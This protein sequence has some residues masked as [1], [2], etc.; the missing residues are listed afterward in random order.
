MKEILFSA[1]SSLTG[2]ALRLTLGII[3][4]PHGAQ[5]LFGLF[6]GYGYKET[7]KYFTDN[8]RLPWIIS[9]AVILIEFFGSVG[10]ILGFGSRIWAALFVLIMFGAIITT[11]YSNGFFMNWFGT[12]KGEGFEYHLLVVGACI[13][14]IITG[15]GKYSIDQLIN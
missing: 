4:L 5:K 3:M 12:Q 8:M 7:M 1:E 15:S 10:L 13:A 11:N 14:I 9:I 2:L 6:G